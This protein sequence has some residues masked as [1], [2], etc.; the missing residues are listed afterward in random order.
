ML[1]V[2]SQSAFSYAHALLRKL[3]ISLIYSCFAVTVVAEMQLG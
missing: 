2:F 3:L 1:P